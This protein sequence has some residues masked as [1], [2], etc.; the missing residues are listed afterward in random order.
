MLRQRARA[1]GRARP[2]SSNQKC[3][4]SILIV[5]AQAWPGLAD[6]GTAGSAPA[7]RMRPSFLCGRRKRIADPARIVVAE[8]AVATDDLKAARFQ[9]SKMASFYDTALASRNHRAPWSL[10][11][12]PAWTDPDQRGQAQPNKN[13]QQRPHGGL[14]SQPPRRHKH[15]WGARD[16]SGEQKFRSPR[17][18]SGSIRHAFSMPLNSIDRVEIGLLLPTALSI[19]PSCRRYKETFP[20]QPTEATSC[21]GCAAAQSAA[22]R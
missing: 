1:Q 22:Q 15:R 2:R 9:I 8:S 11:I 12:G 14:R 4:R 10:A 6:T 3:L 16:G 21:A 18:Q 20:A 13:M 19:P 7:A 17:T 5:Q